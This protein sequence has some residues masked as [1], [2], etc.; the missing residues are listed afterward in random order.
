MDYEFLESLT[1]DEAERFLDEFRKSQSHALEQ[2]RPLAASEG[3]CLD[4]SLSTLADG[5]KWM[6][7]GVRVHRIPVPLEE[8]W[9]IRQAH[10]D[11]LTEFD[12]DSKTM[13]LCASYY[14]GE[15]F[16]RLPGLR[17]STGNDETLH[18]HMPVITGFCFGKELPPL[19]VVS[20]MFARILGHGDSEAG[21]S[22]TIKVWRGFLPSAGA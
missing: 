6:I 3:V 9:W 22:E 16:A 14:F 4:L 11:G 19:V 15:C 18:K 7:K 20:N 10:A 12:E 21:I 8:P 1:A 5:L 13:V 2:L 17:W